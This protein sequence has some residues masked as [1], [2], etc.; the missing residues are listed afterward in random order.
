MTKELN[1]LKVRGNLGEILEMVY[2]N[3]DEYVIKRG[4]KPMAVL[5]PVDEF[6]SYK[7]QREFDMKVSDKIR[8][9]AKTYT[10]KEIETYVNK[11]LNEV[12]KN[13]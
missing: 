6:E 9:K 5:I 8:N 12:R 2:Y 13:A 3:G 4:T 1:A 11:A 10:S 7:K